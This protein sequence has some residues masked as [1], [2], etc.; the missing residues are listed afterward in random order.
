M[1]AAETR[2]SVRCGSRGVLEP[3]ALESA[4]AKYVMQVMDLETR[5]GESEKRERNSG[6]LTCNSSNAKDRVH[7]RG[8]R[9]VT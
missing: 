4:M 9:S 2:W 6:K 3:S 8:R 5:A 1:G 7:W